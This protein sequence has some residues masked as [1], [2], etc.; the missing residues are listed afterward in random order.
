MQQPD[1]RR[2]G[3]A[4]AVLPYIKGVSEPLTRIL[5]K[6]DIRSECLRNRSRLKTLRLQQFLPLPKDR[7]E[8]EKQTN[9]G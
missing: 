3:F 5:K 7:P 6:H 1:Y 4:N 9:V 2:L 8:A